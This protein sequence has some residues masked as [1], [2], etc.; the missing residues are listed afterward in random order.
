MKETNMKIM[1]KSSRLVLVAGLALALAGLV[2][3]P[4]ALFAQGKGASKLMPLKSLKVVDDLQDVEQGDMI[5]MSCPKCKDTYVTKV[6]HSFK[7]MNPEQLKTAV[8]HLCPACETKIVSEGQG[9]AK[10][11]KLVHVCKTCGS[12]DV[13]CCVMKKGGGTTAGMEGAK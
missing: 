3:S 1:K 7:G 2:A 12:K 5:V 10:T 11:D 4:G 13:S 9:K 6:E 8:A